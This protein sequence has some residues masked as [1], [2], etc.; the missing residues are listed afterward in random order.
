[1]KL[2]ISYTQHQGC[3]F[4]LNT[5]LYLDI[6]L[7]IYKNNHKTFVN[8]NLNNTKYPRRNKRW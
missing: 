2:V 1:M 7:L 4:N 8:P 3:L 6:F 5:N